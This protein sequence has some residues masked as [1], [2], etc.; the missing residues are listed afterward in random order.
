MQLWQLLFAA[1]GLTFS[2]DSATSNADAN[3]AAYEEWYEGLPE[4]E[5]AKFQKL[6]DKLSSFNLNG[7]LE[8][9]EKIWEGLKR[10]ANSIVEELTPTYQ[11]ISSLNISNLSYNDFR[12]F[13]MDYFNVPESYVNIP[14]FYSG[15]LN[16]LNVYFQKSHSFIMSSRMT[17]DY[18]YSACAFKEIS[19]NTYFYF[20]LLGDLVYGDCEKV[21]FFSSSDATY[22]YQNVCNIN[23]SDDIFLLCV[24][25][26]LYD[27]KDIVFFD[28]INQSSIIYLSKIANYVPPSSNVISSDTSIAFPTI[29]NGISMSDLYESS[30]YDVLTPGRTF[31]KEKQEVSGNVVITV[32]SYDVLEGY[33][34][35][36]VTWE[37]LMEEANVRPVDTASDSTLTGADSTISDALAGIEASSNGIAGFVEGI[38]NTLTGLADALLSG[39]VG[40]FVP[41]EGYF[42]DYFS[43]LNDFFN[44]KLGF[45]WA[46]VG[47]L[48]DILEA[49]VSSG[50][51]DSGI[52]FPGV[53][54]G[55]YIIIEKQT[56]Y[57]EDYIDDYAGLQDA[58]YFIGDLIMSGCVLYLFQLKI[59]EM[60]VN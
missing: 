4:E 45:L 35:G 14:S 17:Y 6:D 22:S 2:Y 42:A 27:L 31:N 15:Y 23:Y 57:I 18:E 9:P 59:K 47:I 30:A 16:S 58:I 12:N 36:T 10:F 55:G 29:K 13:I 33:N 51:T 44:E 11:P 20:D 19:S 54:Y 24:N 26:Y 41:A 40:L 8:I 52:V 48:I 37:E 5:K 49:L 43:R 25:G 50:N 46:P 7:V 3:I 60:M 53:K 28:G 38:W 21:S 56:V 39:L 1:L 32:P 34:N